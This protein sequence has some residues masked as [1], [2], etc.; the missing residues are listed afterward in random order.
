M[1]QEPDAEKR[2]SVIALA[3]KR[4]WGYDTQQV[5]AFLEKAHALYESDEPRLGQE[6]IQNV[7]FELVKNGFVIAQVD[8]AL[9][10]L[11]RAVVD[12]RT[13]WE[14]NQRG[15]VAWR[16]QTESMFQKFSEHASRAAKERFAAGK[17]KQSSYKRSQV[18]RLID[19]IAQKLSIEL[20]QNRHS[21]NAKDLVDLNAKRVSNVIF[22]QCKGKRGY[23]ERQVDYFLN[24]AVQLLSRVESYVRVNDYTPAQE[25]HDVESSQSQEGL[26]AA[27]LPAQN[28]TASATQVV[29]PLFDMSAR[30]NRVSRDA[31][32]TSFANEPAQDTSFAQSGG[33]D[34]DFNRL[35]AAEKAIFQSSAS[36][37]TAKPEQGTPAENVQTPSAKPDSVNSNSPK[38]DLHESVNFP[39]SANASLAA[40]AASPHADV[41]VP[42]GYSEKQDNSETQISN[43]PLDRQP[44]A[45]GSTFAVEDAATERFDPLSVGGA[46]SAQPR[47]WAPQQPQSATQSVESSNKSNDYEIPGAD[48][49]H[50]AV[51][52]Q[53]AASEESA[54]VET[55]ALNSPVVMPAPATAFSAPSA[56]PSQQSP[57]ETYQEDRSGE[58]AALSAEATATDHSAK[59]GQDPDQYLAELT[60]LLD[61]STFPKVDLDIPDLSFPGFDEGDSKPTSAAQDSKE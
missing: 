20:G 21:E 61:S 60:S 38:Q 39:G 37:V 18:D 11:E 33:Q 12:K 59:Q 44:A 28:E 25:A 29:A 17:S 52:A 55:Q 13:S 31:D 50:A 54:A 47:S 9:A 43:S 30:N 22:T 57:S 36:P 49:P 1:A 35:D 48:K 26:P 58:V 3:G 45:E 8:A 40:L 10:R 23:D 27:F 4:K 41:Q 42:A 34:D 53:Q 7:S 51:S 56:V 14:I 2:G 16:A 19:Q 24:F 6:D 32:A 46:S 5:D 15:R